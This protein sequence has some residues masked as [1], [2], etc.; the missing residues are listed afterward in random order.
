MH[1]G[2]QG[3]R[4]EGLG[5]REEEPH[6]CC[7]QTVPLLHPPWPVHHAVVHQRRNTCFTIKCSQPL[8]RSSFLPLAFGF[9]RP[10]RGWCCVSGCL[11]G[12]PCCREILDC[13][14]LN[15]RQKSSS[16][17]HFLKLVALAF[18]F[19]KTILM[20]N[21]AESQ[22]SSHCY[23]QSCFQQRGLQEH[24]ALSQ[25]WEGSTAKVQRDEFT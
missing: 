23:S 5:W 21:V 13:G 15:L 8:L 17:L 25:R 6:E 4:A 24:P 3:F 18:C 12:F 20:G 16:L 19:I 22:S 7:V 14:D 10:W 2:S 11:C 1:E 9:P